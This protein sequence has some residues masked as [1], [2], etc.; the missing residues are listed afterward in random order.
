M[1][2][3]SL[4]ILLLL[5]MNK[6]TAYNTKKKQRFFRPPCIFS[7][8]T[9]SFYKVPCFV[10][11]RRTHHKFIRPC[12]LTQHWSRQ[13]LMG[14]FMLCRAHFRASGFVVLGSRDW[15]WL[16]NGNLVMLHK[17]AIQALNTG[18]WRF[19]NNNR[20]L[21]KLWNR[22]DKF[23]LQIYGPHWD[24]ITHRHTRQNLGYFILLTAIPADEY[25]RKKKRTL[26]HH[27]HVPFA[28]QTSGF[29]PY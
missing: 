16:W 6:Y 14:S 27:Y 9:H 22:T 12:V 8:D 4:L 11:V 20:L 7:H 19:G 24:R 15:G 21:V 10:W 2:D 29:S 23:F 18:N 1:Q 17:K 26:G 13:R 3:I 25:L 5:I 28:K